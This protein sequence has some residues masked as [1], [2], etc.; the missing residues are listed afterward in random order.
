MPPSRQ[1]RNDFELEDLRRQ[2]QQLQ[3][4]VNAQQVLLE[5]YQQES[6]VDTSSSDSSSTRRRRLPQRSS[7]SDDIRVEIPD[8]EG[9]L[10]PDE[11]VDWFQ[12]V[13]RVFE[14]KEVPEEKK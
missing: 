3:E 1:Q 2:I 4:T 13:E 7:R 10:Q 5:G 9:K 6:E 12:T 8:F 14:Y 11:F